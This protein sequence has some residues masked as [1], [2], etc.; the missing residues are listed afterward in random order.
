MTKQ[1]SFFMFFSLFITCVN[2][3]AM[4]SSSGRPKAFARRTVMP[5]QQKKQVEPEVILT[6][7]SQIS[8]LNGAQIA[9]RKDF[10]PNPIGP[11]RKINPIEEDVKKILSSEPG[12]S[13]FSR[14]SM[15]VDPIIS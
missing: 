5:V 15:F 13:L 1:I 11:N 7:N 3:N 9:A 6:R 12:Y 10:M 14:Q 2:S 4:D 8:L